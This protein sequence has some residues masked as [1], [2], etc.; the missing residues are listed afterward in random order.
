MYK[1]I[2]LPVLN[3]LSPSCFKVSHIIT[4]SLKVLQGRKQHQLFTLFIFYVFLVDQT[5]LGQHTL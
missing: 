4:P 5:Q 3:S 2:K 1:G